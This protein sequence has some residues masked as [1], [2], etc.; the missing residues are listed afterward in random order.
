MTLTNE[1]TANAGATIPC[2]FHQHPG[3]TPPVRAQPSRRLPVDPARFHK[4]NLELALA[5]IIGL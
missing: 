5:V 4:P 2:C 3:M 1:N